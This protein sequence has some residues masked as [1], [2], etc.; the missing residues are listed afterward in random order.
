MKLIEKYLLAL[1]V[2]VATGIGVSARSNIVVAFLSM[3][4]DVLPLVD[5][6]ARL[7]MIDYYDSSSNIGAENVFG[8][9]SRITKIEPGS[10]RIAMSSASQYQLAILP[11]AKDTLVAVISTLL[12]PAPDSRL[13]VYDG[14]WT[15]VAM[16][17]MFEAPDLKDWLTASGRKNKQ[18][19]EALVP[20]MLVGYDFD[21][22][23]MNL[24]LVNNTPSYLSEET[25]EILT[26]YFYDKLVYRWNGKK[27][28]LLK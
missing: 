6:S 22:V 5:M 14:D 7:D 9:R 17:K 28:Q 23:T 25:K 26:G 19:V 10:M 18:K 21:P 11:M 8:G 13:A 27:F 3:P 16:E 4:E 20:F 2:C 24:V 15:P 1:V 12:T